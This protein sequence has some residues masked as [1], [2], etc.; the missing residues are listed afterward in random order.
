MQVQNSDFDCNNIIKST[1]RLA[2]KKVFAQAMKGVYSATIRKRKFKSGEP[3]E[4][5]VYR[6]FYYNEN[7]DVV[8][9]ISFGPDGDIEMKE[10]SEY[11]EKGNI[12][13]SKFILTDNIIREQYEYDGAGRLAKY[14]FSN[15]R[16]PAPKYEISELDKDG[17]LIKTTSYGLMGAPQ[18]VSEY[19]YAGDS[20]QNYRFK[21]VTRSDGTLLITFYFTY[22]N[23]KKQSNIT[24]IYGFNLLPEQVADLLKDSNEDTWQSET[25]FRSIWEYRN[26]K[27]IGFFKDEK[28]QKVHLDLGHIQ[29]EERIVTERST[30]EYEKINGKQHLIKITEWQ[31]RFMEPWKEIKEYT[32]YDEGGN[33]I[34]PPAQEVT[35]TAL[36]KKVK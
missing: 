27:P 12:V 24:G 5:F 3:D 15:P 19:I 9:R 22:E 8:R 31:T 35:K 30:I 4:G 33:P 36:A 13:S 7:G 11:D 21:L 1:Q 10:Q 14:T 26:G 34:F 28:L 18:Y 23:D 25:V 2:R 20:D 16:L 17:R 6:R 32:Y 29:S